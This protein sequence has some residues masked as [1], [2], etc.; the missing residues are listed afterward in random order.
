MGDQGLK[1]ILQGLFSIASI[2]GGIKFS[3]ISFI[4]FSNH[5]YFG[6]IQE[7]FLSGQDRSRA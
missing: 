6:S 5:P 1:Q 2:Y 4:A 3:K 7:Y